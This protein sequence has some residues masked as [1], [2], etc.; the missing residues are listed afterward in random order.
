[1][2]RENL[3]WALAYNAIALP[4]AALGL[5]TPL[6]ASAGMAV[7]SL[8]VVANALRAGRAPQA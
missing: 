5:V 4:A 2:I 1:V 6:M 7:S 3:G 8:I